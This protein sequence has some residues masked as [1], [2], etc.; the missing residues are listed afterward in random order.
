[1]AKVH[2]RAIKWYIVAQVELTREDREGEIQTVQPFFR[3]TTYSLLTADTFEIHDLNEALQK[4]VIGLEKYIHE[5]S[6]WIL[7]TVIKLDI[8]TVLYKPLGGS[9]YMQLPA[10][11]ENSHSVLNIK[12][13]D[14][15]CF[16]WAILGHFHK[17]RER[18]DQVEHYFAYEKELD[19][20]GISFPVSLSKINQFERQNDSISV[21]VFGFES[22]EIFPLKITKQKGRKHHINLLY[23][24][25]GDTS[26]YCLIK[27]L[28]K[29]LFRTKTNSN[30]YHFCLHCLNGFTR[31]DLLEKHQELCSVN[32]EQKIVLPEKGVN[33]ILKFADF[34]KQMKCP[35][36]IYCDFETLNRDIATCAPDPEKSSTTATKH[37]DVCSF[38]MKR[39]CTDPRYTKET[40]VYRGPDASQYFI[41]SLLKEEEIKEILSHVEPLKMREE[42][43]IAF[44]NAV[45][46]FICG[47]QMGNDK[48]I[49]HDHISGNYGGAACSVCNLQ[50][51]VCKFI[52]VIFHD[53]RNFDSHIICQSIGEYEM[54]NRGI[55][56]IP[57]NM[58]RYIS[59]S[60]GDLRFLDSYQ[61]LSSSLECLTENLKATGGLSNFQHFSSEFKND[62]IAE[63]LL[64]KNVYMYDYM[65]DES[66]FLETNLPPKKAFYSH[67]KKTHISEDDFQHACKVF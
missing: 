24:Q 26:H 11:L 14:N 54:K 2:H 18:P 31:E 50:F 63:L 6:G 38:G 29:F 42:D 47:E 59:F 39:V 12:N 15:K 66:K 8:H 56:C 22:G 53:L 27:D 16:V 52:P 67:I 45:K 3:S 62:S 37:L 7:R 25:Y 13:K 35:F 1:M 43:E 64:R 61:F 40:V 33:G 17:V 10:T 28:N 5:S 55:K 41:E 19:M 30:R 58:E 36:V 60:L 51:Q 49:D 44:E 4:L 46:C 32:G 23:L 65:N 48:V 20:K 21:N 34:R 9:S 57:Q